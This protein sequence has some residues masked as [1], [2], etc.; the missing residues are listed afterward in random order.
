MVGKWAV[1]IGAILAV[2]SWPPRP[3]LLFLKFPHMKYTLSALSL[4]LC[5]WMP[6]RF[7]PLAADCC[8][9]C[10]GS[11]YCTACKNCKYCKHCNSGGSCGVCAAPKSR[12]RDYY[13]TPAPP[14]PSR[15]ETA[16]RTHFTPAPTAVPQG[17]SGTVTA[18]ALNLRG[19]PGTQFPIIYRLKKG[20][21]LVILADLGQWLHVRVGI[22][23]GYSLDGYVF[24][25]FVAAH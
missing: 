18:A 21:P 3:R 10:T 12:S 15:H 5:L 19:G 14:T 24:K 7:E 11:A 17:R 6:H 2:W 16:P 8:G 25:K 22:G 13:P 20:D 4:V 1:G 23:S 9:K